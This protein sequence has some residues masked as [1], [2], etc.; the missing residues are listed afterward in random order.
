[1]LSIFPRDVLDEIWDLT[2]SVSEGFP[3]YSYSNIRLFAD[4][5]SLSILVENLV[6]AAQILKSDLDKNTKWAKTWLV[7]FNPVTTET[8]LLSRKLLQTM[9]PPLYMLNQQISEADRHKHLGIFFS[10]N[11]S[12]HK[13]INY[14]KEKAWSRINIMGKLKFQLDRRSLET[15]Y[16]SFIRAILVM[17]SGTTVDSTKKT[18]LKKFKRK[19]REL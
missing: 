7:T 14:I 5:T 4:D 19:R 15:F 9:H 18:T 12:W 13:H 1:M 6:S 3:T 2:E 17:K 16:T 10:N 11:G 8:L